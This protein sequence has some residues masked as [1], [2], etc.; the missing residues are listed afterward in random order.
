MVSIL[1]HQ[2]SVPL[3][4]TPQHACSPASRESF[5]K[6]KR[7]QGMTRKTSSD[8]QETESALQ[9]NTSPANELSVG[10]H[11]TTELGY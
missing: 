6:G 10:V 3:H 11:V 7:S 2:S 5:T 1:C 9:M 8:N 4:R